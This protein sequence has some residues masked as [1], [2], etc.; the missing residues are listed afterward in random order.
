MTSFVMRADRKKVI[1]RKLQVSDANL[2]LEWMSNPDIYSKMQ[3]DH[4]HLDLNKCIFFIKNS[5]EDKH[6]LHFAIS[7][8]NSEYMG[9]IS[10]KNID[11]KNKITELGIAVHPMYMG[12]EIASF[13]LNEIAKKAFFELELNKIYLC[14][15]ADNERAVRFYE[16]NQLEL[17]GCA[18]EHLFAEGKYRDVLW[19]A[20]RKRNYDEWSRHFE[21]IFM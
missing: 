21:N 16:K 20:L 2:M 10:L 19:F 8:F 13:A 7:N 15:R 14:V 17:E 5:W 11:Y 4:K 12:K 1:L 6:N 9:T 18:K 3:Y